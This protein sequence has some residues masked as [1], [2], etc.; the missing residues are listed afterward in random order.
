MKKTTADMDSTRTSHLIQQACNRSCEVL[1]KAGIPKDLN[2]LCLMNFLR[3]LEKDEN[4]N[5]EQK[6]RFHALLQDIIKKADFS[7]SNYNEVQF[8]VEAIRHLQCKERED[9]LKEKLTEAENNFQD[10]KS[11]LGTVLKNYTTIAS[12]ASQLTHEKVEDIEQLKDVTVHALERDE[13]RYKIIA[14]VVELTN[15]MVIKMKEEIEDWKTKAKETEIWKQKAFEM[16]RLA[17]TDALTNLY[18]RRAFDLHIEAMVKAMLGKETYLSIL[19]IDIDHF[20][21][22]N[23][24]YGHDVGD[25]VLKMVASIIKKN[26]NKEGDFAARYGGEEMVLLCEATAIEEARLLAER[27]RSDIENYRFIIKGD[28]PKETT[29]TVSIGVSEI[30]CCKS[31]SYLTD[32]DVSPLVHQFIQSADRALY[33]AKKTGRNRVCVF[34]DLKQ[35]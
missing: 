4:Y 31:K 22:F 32:G 24:T 19:M 14:D 26:A 23:D 12:L 16:E 34:D 29:V 20:K 11:I 17:T 10:L 9:Y 18:N 2:W 8:K 1:L 5:A 15:K 27:I 33:Y 3:T 30:D 25:E 13:D 28:T 35:K 21:K 7:E 6:R